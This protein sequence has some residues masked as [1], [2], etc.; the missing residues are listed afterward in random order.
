MSPRVSLEK[1]DARVVGGMPTGEIGAAR[2]AIYNKRNKDI[3]DTIGMGIEQVQGAYREAGIGGGDQVLKQYE[4]LENELNRDAVSMLG[5]FTL[6]N[7][8]P[9]QLKEWFDAPEVRNVVEEVFITAT[10]RIG[11]VKAKLAKQGIDF[12]GMTVDEVL[13]EVSTPAL[14]DNIKNTQ[15]YYHGAEIFQENL[16]DAI[17]DRLM[18]EMVMKGTQKNASDADLKG[19]AEA[20]RKIAGWAGIYT[21]AWRADK[22]MTGGFFLQ[23]LAAGLI[24]GA[25]AGIG[26][27]SV[28]RNVGEGL[29]MNARRGNIQNATP[30]M[31]PALTKL[32]DKLG[33]V[34]P[35]EIRS[36]M[37][38]DFHLAVGGRVER[39][40][41]SG[42]PVFKHFAAFNAM[43]EH[44][45]RGTA[46]HE[47]LNRHLTSEIGGFLSSLKQTAPR[48]NVDEITALLKDDPEVSAE[49]MMKFMTD[50][51]VPG[52]VAMQFKRQWTDILFAGS[53]KGVELSNEVHFDYQMMTSASE[54]LRLNAW[55]PFYKWRVEARKFYA[56]IILTHPGIYN[57]MQMANEE[58]EKMAAEGNLPP[59]WANFVPTGLGKMMLGWALGIPSDVSMNLVGLVLPHSQMLDQHSDMTDM[60]GH[61]MP[62]D[63][64]KRIG[65][66]LS[67]S[68]FGRLG[69]VPK[70]FTEAVGLT[71]GLDQDVSRVGNAIPIPFTEGDTLGHQSAEEFRRE[72]ITNPVHQFLQSGPQEQPDGTTK[73]VPGD[74]QGTFKDLNTAKRMRFRTHEI[75]HMEAVQED[76][77]G[78]ERE[79]YVEKRRAEL[80]SIAALARYSPEHLRD[81]RMLALGQALNAQVDADVSR[82]G[83]HHGRC[84]LALASSSADDAARRGAVAPVPFAARWRAAVH[85]RYIGLQGP[86]GKPQ[87]I[88][89]A[90]G[91]SQRVRDSAGRPVLDA[92]TAWR[93]L[94]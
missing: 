16:V 54:T 15:K 89:I 68:G 30:E 71:D 75:A 33:I 2:S 12:T 80:W 40:G 65:G 29:W 21:D 9:T 24:Y 23:N 31:A 52:D 8:M 62:E 83:S 93:R 64:A 86:D 7:D 28:L 17:S 91:F 58:G 1:L 43:L 22:L 37:S 25:F 45:M 36:G 51:G 38:A 35:T 85:Q 59:S 66:E 46:W 67:M 18:A 14:R 69:P 88:G 53:R 60:L 42:W 27:S 55:F 92:A 4:K 87:R 94:C 57:A 76:L 56:R 73:T 74:K 78:W 19:L 5:Q 77:V 81:P 39:R 47:G 70:M 13:A 50:H 3:E 84:E 79:E 41:V 26:I 10:G 32:E 82:D 49:A 48:A 72:K 6:P 20:G 90:R 11:G 44:A 61:V 63:A 34:M